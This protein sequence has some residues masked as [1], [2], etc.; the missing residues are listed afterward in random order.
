MGRQAAGP[1]RPRPSCP[2]NAGGTNYVDF[3]ALKQTGAPSLAT[4]TVAGVP[5]TL[6]A[7]LVTTPRWSSRRTSDCR[8]ALLFRTRT[9]P[10]RR[11]ARSGVRRRREKAAIIAAGDPGQ[12]TADPNFR[13]R[14]R[15]GAIASQSSRRA[16]STTSPRRPPPRP[17]ISAPNSTTMSAITASAIPA[18]GHSRAAASRASNG[19]APTPP[20]S[21]A[22][23]PSRPPGRPVQPARP[24][25][26]FGPQRCHHPHALGAGEHPLPAKAR[27][28]DH[29]PA[30][31]WVD[32][33]SAAGP[34]VGVSTLR[35]GLV[36]DYAA[37]FYPTS[38]STRPARLL[39]RAERRDRRADGPNRFRPRRVEGARRDRGRSARR[40]RRRASLHRWRER[41]MNPKAINTIRVFPNASSIGAPARWTAMTVRIGI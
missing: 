24:A 1:E 28:P 13:G 41:V 8:S 9:A 16:G 2:I 40:H 4:I 26:G 32:S 6:G 12:R 14:P 11:R 15:S 31:D 25:Q 20:I 36:K 34:T 39:C 10:K 30:A 23:T 35:T 33:Q 19:G 17:P 5:V 37:V 21:I 3:A 18:S 38:R 7:L 29:G 22:P 27:L